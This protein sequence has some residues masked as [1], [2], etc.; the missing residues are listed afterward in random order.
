MPRLMPRRAAPSALAT[1]STHP[2]T[3]A[4]AI[5][6]AALALAWAALPLAPARAQTVSP[7]SVSMSSERLARIVPAFRAEIER[8]IA[9]GA[10][11]LIARDGKIVHHEA[12]GFLDSAKT[13][14]MPKDAIFRGFSMTKPFTSVATLMLMEEGKLQMQDPISRWLPPLKGLKV[15][16]ERRDKDGNTVVETV[17]SR[18]E[19]TV[20]DLLR[21]TSGFVYAGS[22]SVK[23]VG[24]AYI[25]ADLEARV[26][27][28]TNDEFINGLGQ[29]PLASQPGTHFE[30]SI[31]TDVLGILVEKVTGKRLDVALDEMIFKPL[32]MKDTRFQ[33]LPADLSRLADAFDADPAKKAFWESARV[34]ADPGKRY[35]RGG[36]GAVTT[37]YDYFLFMQMVANGGDLNGK[38]LLS[39]KT[40]EYMLSDHS[41]GTSG[42]PVAS[43]GPGYGFGLGFAV[44]RQD[45]LGVAPGS[46]GDAM[47]AG[48]G[49][50]SF[51]IDPKERIVGVI[52][53]AGPST[54]GQSRMWFKNLLYGAVV[55]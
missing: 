20:Q 50:T 41:Q 27:D 26:K 2:R 23:S 29:V 4:N 18:R 47:W 10:V 8:G 42:S 19:I 39:K 44:R 16:V 55:K 46:T 54:R 45:G 12:T 25:A 49:G 5:T 32:G 43:T 3:R 14:P 11:T 22:A 48:A 13:K 7:E 6:V 30:Y 51:T 17:P 21:H 31:S 28:T 1:R 40:V 53:T 33:A 37:A 38:R 9:P 52:M 15:A 24:A 34:E 35:L 36:A